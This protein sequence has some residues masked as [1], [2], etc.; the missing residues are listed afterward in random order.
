MKKHRYIFLLSPISAFI[1]SLIFLNGF[2]PSTVLGSPSSLTPT[3]FVYLPI[4]VKPAPTPTPI[5]K[6]DPNNWLENVNYFR[7]IAGVMPVTENATL[8]NNCWEHAR[9]IAENNHL[10]HD[11]NPGLP[12]ASPNG[13][14]CAQKGNAWLGGEFFQPYW[15]VHHS[16]E[17]WMGSVGHRAWL[18]YPTTPTFGYGFYTA[19][20]NRAGAALDVLSSANFGADDSYPGWPVIYPAMNQID[21]PA[22][23]YPITIIWQYF[24]PTP[25]LNS[26]SLTTSGGASI[27]HTADTNLPV[28]HEGIQIYPTQDLPANTTIT[29]MVSGAYDGTPFEYSWQFTTGKSLV[30]IQGSINET[31]AGD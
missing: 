18:L 28:G 29:V 2:H 4:V 19:S 23:A 12:Y 22:T 27:P 8:N 30:N 5:P 21:I 10:T 25:T 13:Q 3:A 16:I 11:Q 26:S 6:P 9:Y 20:N 7:S 24:G 1:L 17:G 31:A 14:I 15:E